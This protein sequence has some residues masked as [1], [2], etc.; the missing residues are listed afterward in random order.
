MYVPLY[1]LTASVLF[2]NFRME[3]APILLISLHL[4]PFVI[5]SP[6]TIQFLNSDTLV[7]CRG[8]PPL[9]TS[10]PTSLPDNVTWLDISHNAITEL[11]VSALSRFHHLH[12]LDMSFNSFRIISLELFRHCL[13]LQVLN[14]SENKLQSLDLFSGNSIANAV[15]DGL[16]GESLPTQNGTSNGM[17]RVLNNLQQLMLSQNNIRV[18]SP[19]T[20][21]G[22]QSL[23]VLN[24]SHNGLS[25]VVNDSFGQLSNLEDLDL[26][27]NSI[28]NLESGSLNGLNRLKV[29]RLSFNH[30]QYDYISLPPELFVPVGDSLTSLYLEG[31]AD[32][33][34]TYPE[35]T[36]KA[37]SSLLLL[38]IDSFLETSFGE[39]I[40]VV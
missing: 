6:C 8:L 33:E 20:F 3:G 37:L 19:Q 15:S 40:V 26:S 17:L 32:T 23:R 36:F 38:K 11:N 22:L 5:G 34:G 12:Y 16:P 31:N 18:V 1:V 27:A 29:L 7:T 2:L 28:R 30:L 9:D 39:G 24:M 10:L 21:D 13:D 25:T 14:L 4:L 35:E